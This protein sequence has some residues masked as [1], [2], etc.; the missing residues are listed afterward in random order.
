VWPPLVADVAAVSAFLRQ[1]NEQ[2]VCYC[3][4]REQGGDRAH[5]LLEIDLLVAPGHLKRFCRSA[6]T[7]GYLQLPSWGHAPH[8]FFLAHD[9]G[10]SLWL[11]LDVVTDL[12]YGNPVAAVHAASAADCLARRSWQNGIPRLA[13]EDEFLH[14][15]LH[16]LLDKGRVDAR[17]RARVSVL[18]EHISTDPAAT[19]RLFSHCARYL[20]PAIGWRALETDFA[21]DDLKWA[22]AERHSLA[23]HLRRQDPIRSRWLQASGHLRRRLHPIAAAAAGRGCTIALLGPDGAG[24]TTL[25]KDLAG[26]LPLRTRSIYMGFGARAQQGGPLVRRWLARL[27]MAS[28]ADAGTLRRR[29]YGVMRLLARLVLQSSRALVVRMHH[30]LGRLVL[31]DRHTSESWLG[32][33]SDHAERWSRR[34][35]GALCPVDLVLVLDAPAHV[36]ADRKQDQSLIELAAQRAA[37]STLA[38]RLPD[39]VVIDAGRGVD[40]V[41]HD[42]ADAIWRAY[43]RSYPW[44]TR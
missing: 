19:V 38:V 25:A 31:L 9:E 16:A 7:A 1:L 35:I 36:L 27:A 42:A 11:K 2:D 5:G 6:A 34:V 13:R 29:A 24:K 22:V 44:S 32:A 28:A 20:V 33:D 17:H 43:T 15:I 40:E 18:R 26:A 39:A 21:T 8:H 10:S 12:R 3:L 14:L 4:L 30:A 37:Y 23:L 41:R